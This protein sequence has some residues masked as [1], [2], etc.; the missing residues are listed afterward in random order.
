MLTYQ[1]TI[2]SV[3]VLT[4][5]LLTSWSIVHE[6]LM[7]II[8]NWAG[9]EIG[10]GAYKGYL[11]GNLERYLEVFHVKQ[12]LTS[13]SLTTRVSTYGHPETGDYICLR[14]LCMSFQTT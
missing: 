7:R 6:T 13:W 12:L 14:G 10:V 2:G 4:Y 3:S 11:K 8:L 1:D 9:V 5:K